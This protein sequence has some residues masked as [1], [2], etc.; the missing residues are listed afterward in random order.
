MTT[1]AAPK[2]RARARVLEEGVLA[3]LEADRV[4][5]ALS[6]D[7]PEARLEHR[8]A[9][10]VEH[11]REPRDL[12]LGRD[13]VEE[14]RHRLLGIEQVGV[15]VDVEDVR[16]APHLLERDRDGA[17][18]VAALD[19]PAK[20]SRTGHV[21]P[22]AD[23]HEAGVLPDHERLEARQACRVAARLGTRLGGR[24]ETASTIATMCSGVVPQQPPT[25][26]RSPALANSASSRL[27]S[28]GCSSYPPKAFGQA[29]VRMARHVGRRDPGQGLHVRA[30]LR[31]AERAVDADDQRVGVLDG[32]PPRLDGLPGQRPA[33]EVD[34]RSPTATAAAPG[35]SAR[36]AAIAALQL[37]VS[38]I[39]SIRR[40]S[41]P[42]S[43]RAADLL[44][45]RLADLVE[46]VRAVRRVLHPRRERERDVQRADRAG[47]ESRSRGILRRPLVCG[48]PR[49]PRA[50]EVHL[51][52][53]SLEPVVGLSDRRRGE[54]VRRRDVRARRRSTSRG[55]TRRSPA[56]SG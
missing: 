56:G 27:V 31:R 33:R 25:T 55:S 7:A 2:S 29:G 38:K 9:R 40:R 54:G 16:P 20:P 21:R 22:L 15:H 30:H 8:P 52:D 12:R 42:P 36:A 13:Q 48:G 19:Q 37:S 4:D 35:A 49:E 5:D 14:P 34:D 23:H 17:L 50:G 1:T 53:R 44:R 3:L 46:R 51:P 39:V 10:A 41:T 24:P 11:D 32:D 26:L 6:L 47:D 28:G 45:V 18:V 43:R